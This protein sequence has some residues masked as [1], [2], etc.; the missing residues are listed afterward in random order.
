MLDLGSFGFKYALVLLLLP[1]LWWCI[2]FIRK[3]RRPSGFYLPRAKDMSGISTWRTKGLK[4]LP[5]LTYAGLSCLIIALARPQQLEKNEIV[6]ESGIDISLAIDLSTSMLARDFKPNR[7]EATKSLAEEFVKARPNDR[8]SISVFAGEALSLC[9]LTYDHNMVIKILRGLSQNT[10]TDGT[11]IGTG[12]AS[13]VNMLKDSKAK[14]KVIILLT[15]GVNTAGYIDPMTAAGLAKTFGIRVYAIGVGSEGQAE[16]PVSRTPS[17]Q[18]IY[19]YVPVEIDEP[20]MTEIANLT[21]GQYFRAKD[22]NSLQQIY[23]RIN[24][25]E[26]TKIEKTVL[27]KEFDRYRF[28]LILGSIFLILEMVLSNTVLRTPVTIVDK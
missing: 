9:P 8:I 21:N 5:W 6:N 13:A 27:R 10:L 28:F 3:N 18:I 26:K 7:L 12:L 2:Y 23:N 4:Y 17:G 15:D 24:T 19:G 20:L 14:S 25:L 22:E 16:T 11:A 1:I